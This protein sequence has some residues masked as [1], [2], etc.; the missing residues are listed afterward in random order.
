MCPINSKI[1]LRYQSK[2][3]NG[4]YI[5]FEVEIWNEINFI[6]SCHS[7]FGI[8]KLYII[9]YEVQFEAN[10]NTMQRHTLIFIF[11]FVLLAKFLG[12]VHCG[13]F[14][15]HTIIVNSFSKCPQDEKNPV[16]LDFNLTRISFNKYSI[17]CI[18]T[19]EE[20]I[21]GPIEV[22]ITERIHFIY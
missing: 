22:N 15:A 6:R 8:F 16:H 9:S 4:N 17:N 18:F 3:L 20:N 5:N 11:I 12:K 10:Q 1:K 21:T 14:D 19:V 7:Q 2:I 13:R